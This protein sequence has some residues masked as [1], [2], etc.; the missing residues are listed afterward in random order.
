MRGVIPL[1]LLLNAYA[2]GAFPMAETAD[3]PEISWIRPHVRA[4]LPLK[5][6]H[7]PAR[8]ARTV[9]GSPWRVTLDAAFTEV[10]AACGEATAG[11][12]ETWIN[13]AIRSAFVGLHARGLTHSV[14][15]WDDDRLVGGLYGLRLGGAFFG[16]SMFSRATDASKIAL[17]HLAGRLNRA[18]FDLLDA[19]FENP[20]LDQFGAE[21]VPHEDY[22]TRLDA[23]LAG[24][25]SIEAFVA[26]MS[27]AEAVGYARQPTTQAS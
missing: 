25:P 5:P 7:V 18:G 21:A 3:D 13:A 26:P 19:Q 17:V 12:P 11:R 9:R 16:E 15:V 4:V 22:L 10:I 14:E 27:G 8:L 20:H 6:F 2:Q 24:S 1:D 23:A